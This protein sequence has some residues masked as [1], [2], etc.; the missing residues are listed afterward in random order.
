MPIQS[1][2]QPVPKW[3][4]PMPNRS[5][6]H[7]AWLCGW[8]RA[9]RAVLRAGAVVR[10]LRPDLWIQLVPAGIDIGWTM[11]AVPWSRRAGA[12]RAPL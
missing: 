7:R 4:R 3:Q 8:P 1:M 2:I 9:D 6:S 10:L 12:G 5:A 11:M